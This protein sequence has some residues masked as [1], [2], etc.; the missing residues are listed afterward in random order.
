M[1]GETVSSNSDYVEFPD[2][3]T[4]GPERRSPLGPD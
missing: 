2:N 4:D 3:S 1:S